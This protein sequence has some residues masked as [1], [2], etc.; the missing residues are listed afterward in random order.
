[1]YPFT[2]Y[3]VPSNPMRMPDFER[4]GHEAGEDLSVL[5]YRCINSQDLVEEFCV[6]GERTASATGIMSY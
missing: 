2:S 3:L 5:A 4:R 6:A 1:M